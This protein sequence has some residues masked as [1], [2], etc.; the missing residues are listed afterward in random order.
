MFTL[1]G[2]VPCFVDFLFVFSSF[3][4]YKYRS[5]S[6]LVPCCQFNHSL[7]LLI[8]LFNVSFMTQVFWNNFLTSV[9][10]PHFE[11]CRVLDGPI[12][13]F[14]LKSFTKCLEMNLF[15]FA[16]EMHFCSYFVWRDCWANG[17]LLSCLASE[18]T[19]SQK[20]RRVSEKG[21]K[22]KRFLLSSNSSNDQKFFLTDPKKWKRKKSKS[23]FLMQLSCIDNEV[24]M[25]TKKSF[26]TN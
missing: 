19:T 18:F 5:V 23:F 2:Q 6:K 11:N 1:V 22:S 21:G 9:R 16:R 26:V 12:R 17:I 24:A 13:Y 20:Q 8:T 14:Y 15:L 7:W 4:H 25:V 3:I 10:W